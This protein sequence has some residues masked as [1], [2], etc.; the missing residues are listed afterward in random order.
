MPKIGIYD[1]P[2]I[3]LDEAIEYLKILKENCGGNAKRETFSEAISKK[4]GWFNVIVG[5]MV[6]YGLIEVGQGRV[7]ISELGTKIL[8]GVSE[9]EKQ[10]AK[11]EAAEKIRLFSEISK[12]FPEGVD[13]QKLKLFLRDRTSADLETVNLES[14]K[15]YKIYS[16]TSKYLI[17][18]EKPSQKLQDEGPAGGKKIMGTE[19]PMQVP[20]DV[21][22]VVSSKDY[23]TIY[24]KDEI[25]VAFLDLIVKKLKE[26]YCKTDNEAPVA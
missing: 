5:S 20:S 22:L 8:F 11:R 18:A 21:D 7:R 24:V 15:I 9:D 3:D 10:T 14:S 17:P 6:D 26:K 1:Y 25:G 23:G 4:G 19:I 12:T 2:A 13:E 16:V